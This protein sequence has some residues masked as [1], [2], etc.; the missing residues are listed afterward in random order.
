ML[1]GALKVAAAVVI[2]LGLLVS[3]P[4]GDALARGKA[5]VTS[6][7]QSS[8]KASKKTARGAKKQSS[9][10]TGRIAR[11][12]GKN[13][14]K[15]SKRAQTVARRSTRRGK[16]ESSNRGARRDERREA[17]TTA[18][19]PSRPPVARAAG[20]VTASLDEDEDEVEEET[21]GPRPAN[22][23]VSSISPAR[24]IEIQN[25]LIQKGVFPGTPTGVYDQATFSAMSAFQSR[26]GLG[27]TGMPTAEALKALGV[28]KNS[29]FGFSSPTSVLETTALD[30]PERS[31]PRPQPQPSVVQNPTDPEP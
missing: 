24:V 2:A 6:K 26:S 27:A 1:R 21:A 30:S 7:K 17:R 28:R 11:K 23:L 4:N 25:A 22:R 14:R 10:K 12:G 20:P 8:R 15:S 3:V 5:K 29:G 18:S 9:R 16:S 19:S 31:A 13:S